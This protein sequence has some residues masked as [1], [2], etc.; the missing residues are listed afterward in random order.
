MFP[1]SSGYIENEVTELLLVMKFYN[2]YRFGL[3][4]S[5]GGDSI[6]LLY[7]FFLIS[8][9]YFRKGNDVNFLNEKDSQVDERINIHD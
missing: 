2:K 8:L 7:H 3:A 5:Q 9:Y 6:P 4:Q 1:G